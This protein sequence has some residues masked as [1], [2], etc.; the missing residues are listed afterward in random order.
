MVIIRSSAIA[1]EVE[2]AGQLKIAAAPNNGRA[3]EPW[4]WRLTVGDGSSPEPA[5]NRQVLTVHDPKTGGDRVLELACEKT[6][7]SGTMRPEVLDSALEL[8]REEGELIVIYLHT[9]ELAFD[10]HTLRPGDAAVI[11]G[12]EH[13]SVEAKPVSDLAGFALVRLGAL[14]DTGLVWIP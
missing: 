4:Q 13:Y 14:A 3:N 8:G 10:Q 9:G 12:N 5:L 6:L 7:V 11:S 1:N 2:P